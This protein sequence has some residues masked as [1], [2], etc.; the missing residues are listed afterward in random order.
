MN[1]ITENFVFCVL[2]LASSAALSLA[3]PVMANS[4][5]AM[6]QSLSEELQV[7]AAPTQNTDLAAVSLENTQETQTR[8]SGKMTRF[9]RL[10]TAVVNFQVSYVAVSTPDGKVVSEGK[11]V[12]S[13]C[14]SCG[15]PAAPNVIVN[16]KAEIRAHPGAWH[17]TGSNLDWIEIDLGQDYP[18]SKVVFYNR[19]DCCQ[20]RSNGAVL[21][22]LDSGRGTVDSA[23]LNGDN[24][25]IFTF[26]SC[27][28]DMN[29][30]SYSNNHAESASPILGLL[31]G[32]Q[33]KIKST[34]VAGAKQVAAVKAA[35]ETKKAVVQKA[36][37]DFDK[38][39]A[40]AITADKDESNS[41][42]QRQ[43]ELAMIDTMVAMI[44][45]LNGKGLGN[46]AAAP[47]V[48]IAELAGRPSGFYFVK[49]QNEASAVKMYVDNDRNGGGWVLAARVTTA[50]CQ[51]HITRAAVGLKSAN[52]GPTKGDT[53]TTKMSDS[54]IQ[55]LRSSSSAKGTI[56]FWMEAQ[57][58]R[59]DTFISSQA[60]VNL[61]SS[62]SDMSQRTNVANTYSTNQ[63][64]SQ[65]GPN[66]G[67]RGFGDHHT[68]SGTYFAW[69][70][71]PEQ[72]SNC[73]FRE[74]VLGSSNGFLWVR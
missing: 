48:D 30:A 32:L 9:V 35:A 71:H 57:D 19:A 18:V 59:K 2:L 5:E 22:L 65:R 6:L 33:M 62:A 25:Q 51:A 3:V 13:S 42:N 1:F 58:F 72:G 63:G 70:R 7:D 24:M 40:A 69:G 26:V 73:G 45:A 27:D 29:T 21:T 15:Y 64:L 41:N 17:S 16:G 31:C 10:Q 49:P 55:N 38:A 43:K 60:T 34:E 61:E 67:T 36:Q 20:E 56:G 53:V 54:F 37:E 46:S 4:D 74:D 12:T 14:G 50:S 47:I 28:I 23:L 66:T 8:H 68:S 44:H 39:T 11:G 52:E